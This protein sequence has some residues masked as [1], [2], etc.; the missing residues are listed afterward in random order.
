MI[1]PDRVRERTATAGARPARLEIAL[2]AVLSVALLV[3]A[4]TRIGPAPTP[5]TVLCEDVPVDGTGPTLRCVFEEGAVTVEVPWQG[6]A[7]EVASQDLEPFRDLPEQG[8]FVP[9]AAWPLVDV[10]ITRASNGA[11][12]VGFDPPLA[13]TVEYDADDFEAAQ[14]FVSEGELGLGVWDAANE[15]WIVA[16]YGVFHEGFW[17]ADPI[18]GGDLVLANDDVS[19]PPRPRYQMFG[20]EDGGRAVTVVAASLPTLPLAWGAVPFDPDHMLKGFDGPCVVDVDGVECTST[21][22]GVTVRVPYQTSGV[23]PRVVA[24]PWNKA[25]TFLP[26]TVANDWSTG[27]TVAELDRRLMN[28]VVVDENDPT[29]YLTLF[30]PPMEIEIAYLPEDTADPLDAPVLRLAFWDELLEQI[31]VLGGG[32]KDSC[33]DG[34]YIPDCP[35]GDAIEAIPTSDARFNGNFFLSDGTGGGLAKFAFDRWGDRMVAFAR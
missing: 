25:E 23:V 22:M 20:S 33:N 6:W 18:A 11:P 17:L 34:G 16:G 30:D 21:M 12:V 32:P 2:L 35:W 5:L 7:V 15:A 9:L 13:I 31:V 8:D 19:D 27:D 14:P 3:A 1:Q 28:F 29:T 4:C 10:A 24:L 26:T